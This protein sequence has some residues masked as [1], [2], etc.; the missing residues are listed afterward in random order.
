VAWKEK[1]ISMEKY[2]STLNAPLS[3]QQPKALSFRGASMV[4]SLAKEKLKILEFKS[5][6]GSLTKVEN[7]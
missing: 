4:L 5:W 7:R 6:K 1:G 2:V 3:S